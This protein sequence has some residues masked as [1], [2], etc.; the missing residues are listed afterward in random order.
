MV[1]GLHRAINI[2]FGGF[3]NFGPDFAAGRIDAGKFF[4][5]AGGNPP[6]VDQHLKGFRFGHGGRRLGR[7][8]GR[9][10]N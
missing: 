8:L 5:I 6:A 3:G 9:L 4:P 2:V 10:G 1:R 7:R